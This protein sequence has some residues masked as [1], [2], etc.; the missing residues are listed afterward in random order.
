MYTTPYG[1]DSQ[2]GPAGKLGLYSIFCD[3]LY[4]NVYV[5]N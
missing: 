3:N 2:Q 5:Y 1:M 4:E